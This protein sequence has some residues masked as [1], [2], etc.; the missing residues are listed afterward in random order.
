MMRHIFEMSG[1]DGQ[2]E[3]LLTGLGLELFISAPWIATNY[4]FAQRDRTLIWIDGGY[5][6]IG[7]SLMVLGLF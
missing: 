4:V 1:I 6:V 7:S 5:A 2:G 3:G